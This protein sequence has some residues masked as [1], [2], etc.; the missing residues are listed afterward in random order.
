MCLDDSH[1][2]LWLSTLR[3][4]PGRCLF[5]HGTKRNTVGR[6]VSPAARLRRP[7]RKRRLPRAAARSE[8][9]RGSLC[10]STLHHPLVKKVHAQIEQ[11]GAHIE[12][13][14]SRSPLTIGA[15][16][17]VDSDFIT[18]AGGYRGSDADGDLVLITKIGRSAGDRL[19]LVANDV[20]ASEQPPMQQIDI[21]N[22]DRLEEA[23]LESSGAVGGAEVKSLVV[24]S[25]A[26]DQ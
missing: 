18:I 23:S 4:H 13:I 21:G 12:S 5:R 10:E 26:I 20:V 11:A 14:G 7:A 15:V 3:I 16:L 2:A 19:I 1:A 9:G 22:P 25:S 24:G 17:D 6:P 8:P